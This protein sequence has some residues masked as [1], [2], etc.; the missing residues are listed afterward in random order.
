SRNDSITGEPLA[1]GLTE[2]KLSRSRP[3]PRCTVGLLAR[4]ADVLL[5]ARGARVRAGRV[6]LAPH[7]GVE[8]RDPVGRGRVVAPEA[9]G[10]EVVVAQILGEA[11]RRVARF[12]EA[13]DGGAVGLHLLPAAV[14]VG[15]RGDDDVLDRAAEDAAEL[16]AASAGGLAADDGERL[17]EIALLDRL[18]PVTERHVR[19]LVGEDP[20]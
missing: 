3:P 18:D 13:H 5:E 14:A 12:A 15:H 10:V 1:N 8:R 20:G 16:R 2:S 4:A 9:A 17:G 19:D 11:A 7:D 6:A